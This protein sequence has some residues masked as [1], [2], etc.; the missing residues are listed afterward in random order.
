MAY[1]AYTKP[2]RGLSVPYTQ[3]TQA[4]GLLRN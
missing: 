2:I 4:R 3:C 1:T